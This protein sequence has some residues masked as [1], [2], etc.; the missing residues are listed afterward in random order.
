MNTLG[1]TVVAIGVSLVIILAL[2]FSRDTG[3][4]FGYKGDGFGTMQEALEDGAGKSY[5]FDSEIG[6]VEFDDGVIF[7][8]KSKDEHII[9]SYMFRNRQKTKYYLESYYV[10]NDIKDTEWHTSKNKVKTN[11]KLTDAETIINECDN[12]PVQVENYN[13]TINDKDVG[14]KLYYNR[15][16]KK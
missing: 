7:V 5:S 12:L 4:P 9:L 14:L 8:C 11:Y 15:V 2:V 10:V 16:D 13:V 3:A 6:T 1:K